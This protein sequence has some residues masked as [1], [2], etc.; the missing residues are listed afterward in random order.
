MTLYA[1]GM[2]DE[3]LSKALRNIRNAAVAGAAAGSVAGSE[4]ALVAGAAAALGAVVTEIVNAAA[5]RLETGDERLASAVREDAAHQVRGLEPELTGRIEALV[6]RSEAQSATISNF[7]AILEAWLVVWR[8]TVDDRKRKMITAGLVNA[9][10]PEAYEEG[11]TQELL[12]FC[13]VLNY[14]D[15]F[16]LQL[17]GDCDWCSLAGR[18]PTDADADL[19]ELPRDPDDDALKQAVLWATRV[20]PRFPSASPSPDPKKLL[21]FRPYLTFDQVL[22][23]HGPDVLKVLSPDLWGP[24]SWGAE[25]RGRLNMHSLAH[26]H[27]LTLEAQQL[28]LW[29]QSPRV[30]SSLSTAVHPVYLEG[31]LRPTSIG[32][33][34]IKFI[35]DPQ[36]VA[37]VD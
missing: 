35:R 17:V 11:L 37:P 24:E 3:P 1:C 18:L 4:P 21:T 9:F 26:R 36:R 8:R 33:R 10:D 23:A 12:R 6:A 31:N 20:A 34:L 19:G 16:T 7:A 5:S 30:Q 15:L 13:D 2:S 25:R 27:L 29:T 32:W 14:G 28:V 22:S